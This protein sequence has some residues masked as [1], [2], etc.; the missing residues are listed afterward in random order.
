MDTLLT[1][2]EAVIDALGGLKAV[3]QLTDRTVQNV[4]NWKAVGKFPARHFVTMQ[5]ALHLRGRAASASLWS[6]NPASN[7]K[8]SA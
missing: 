7:E 8:A 3:A 4:W 2:A 1:T 6:M 5:A